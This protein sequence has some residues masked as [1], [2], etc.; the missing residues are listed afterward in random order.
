MALLLKINALFRTG[1][2]SGDVLDVFPFLRF[3]FPGLA[4]Y[5]ERNSGTQSGHKYLR[6]SKY[7]SEYKR[8]AWSINGS[9]LNIEEAFL[10]VTKH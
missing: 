8:T 7:K 1:N 2:P 3:I 9:H 5:R 6:V 4:G 10:V